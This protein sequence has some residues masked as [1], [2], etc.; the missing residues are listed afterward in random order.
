MVSKILIVVILFTHILT[1]KVLKYRKKKK[2][3]EKNFLV[4]A[5][6]QYGIRSTTGLIYSRKE[7]V[8]S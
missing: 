7:P 8:R 6:R 5:L 1:P 3:R 4:I 2:K